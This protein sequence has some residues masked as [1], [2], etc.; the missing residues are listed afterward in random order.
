MKLTTPALLSLLLISF[1]S[2][3]AELSVEDFAAQRTIIDAKISPS[4]QFL[5][6]TLSQNNSRYLVIRDLTQPNFPIT[7]LLEDP[8]VRPSTLRW[9]NNERLIVQLLVPFQTNKVRY[10]FKNDPDFNIDDYLMFYRSVSMDTKA[11]NVVQLMENKSNFTV[12]NINLGWISNMLPRE[13]NYIQMPAIIKNRLTLNKVDITT[14]DAST[15]ATGNK[16]TF[17]FVTDE[18][19]VPTHRLDYL[20]RAKEI[21]VFQLKEKNRWSKVDSLYFNPLDEESSDSFGLLYF[22][23][24]KDSELIYRKRNLSTGFYEIVGEERKS[25]QKRIIARLPNQSIH[26]L[27]QGS[28][29]SHIIGYRV[30]S[31]IMRSF[32]F[33]PKLQ[34]RYDAIAAQVGPVNFDLLSPI[35]QSKKTTLITHGL[36][37]PGTLYTFDYASEK[38][39]YVGL[40]HQK[41]PLE[42]LAK[43]AITSYKAKDGTNIRAYILFPPG[44]SKSNPLPLV[45]LPHGGPNVRDSATYDNLAQ[46]IATRGY[47]VIK[48]NFR[49]SSGSGWKFEQ[50]G[51]RQWGE[52][53]QSDV[54]DAASFLLKEKYVKKGKICIVGASYGGYSALVATIKNPEL[55]SCSI[56]INGIS[57]LHDLIEN[58]IDNSG[59]FRQKIEAR[60][61]Q[62]V[63]NPRTDLEYLNRNSP[64]LHANKITTPILL[65]AG[66]DD[67]IVPVSQSRRMASALD[68]SGSEFRFVEIENV[69]HNPFLRTESRKITYKEIE[70]FLAKYLN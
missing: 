18:A 61:Y 13:A 22:G 26:S 46:F 49:G 67:D 52:L 6:M 53:M 20:K 55:Y 44:Y 38:L 1:L 8:I 63:G 25:S 51:Y 48:P 32:Y 28:D 7:G 68:D 62:K 39:S 15:I 65:I 41:L 3:A 57:N 36:T 45:V 5:A 31:D 40:L 23:I 24:G 33:D 64:E 47:I 66:E 60:I 56:S 59:V 4:G 30:Q 29:S 19:G 37:N 27:I 16:R 17:K 35:E 12:N 70:D 50:Q 42:K 10:K 21:Q 43:S 9:A 11:T 2:P 54:D 58:T 69:G 14:G 34:Q